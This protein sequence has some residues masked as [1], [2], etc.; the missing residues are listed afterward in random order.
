MKKFIPI[1]LIVLLGIFLRFFL[2]GVVPKGVTNDEVGY[3][4]N[5]YSIA[6]TGQNVFG[7]FL[8]FLTWVNKGGTPFLPVP[9]YL[10]APFFWIFDLSATSARLPSAILGVLDIILL[11]VL[12]KKLFNNN[13]L[14]VL[15]ALFLA[16][17]SWHLHLSR[18]AYDPNYA[19]FFYLLGIVLFILEIEKKRLP[20]FSL[21]SFFLAIY[22]FRGMNLLFFPLSL[23]LVWFSIR[24][25]KITKKQLAFSIGGFFLIVLSLALVIFTNGEKYIAEAGRFFNREVAQEE[26]DQ[27]IREAQG[28]L[29][30]RRTF[31]NKAT[32]ILDNLRENYINALSP[33]FL[34]LH[35]ES[36]QIYSIWSRGRI[37]FIDLVFII[38]GFV[39]LFK[40]NKK[41]AFFVTLLLL[42]SA[43]PA[44]LSGPPF[45]ARN[46]F[47]SVTL[48]IFSA[49][50]TLLV[51]S[52]LK[53]Q[54]LK[55]VGVLIIVTLYCYSFTS[56]LFD[57][58]GRFA[59]Y[60]AEPWFK[61]LKDLSSVIN[62]DKQNYDRVIIGRSSF[63]DLLQYAF[64]SK[65]NPLEVQKSWKRSLKDGSGSFKLDKVEFRE[66]CFE[67]KSG[68]APRFP[69]KKVLYIV[70]EGCAVH[71]SPNQVI[72]D[73]FGN[74]VWKIY[75]LPFSST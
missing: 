52:Y 17:S 14:A 18:T 46:F 71:S 58:Y 8:P 19:L 30:I 9:I 5:A 25:L 68:E 21:T 64:Y 69:F 2:L 34:F 62:E 44:V 47:M 22:S 54:N 7:E 61:S 60:A 67:G 15:S 1:I 57:Y 63:Q 31:L 29:S 51:L 11:F 37:Y 27:Q 41:R 55:T 53:K 75:R 6:K 26:I 70:H 4:Y 65:T 42:S 33:G 74:T 56:Y 40:L 24:E 3:I 20:M 43:L 12:V 28:P 39:F 10:S 35:G 50:G 72:S 32:Y 45:S 73:Y 48:P 49:G 23:I 38:L 16:I 66:Q 59:Y 13:L 36:T